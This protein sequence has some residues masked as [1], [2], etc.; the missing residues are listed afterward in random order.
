MFFSFYLN[1]SIILFSFSSCPFWQLYYLLSFFLASP[2]FSQFFLLF[3]LVVFFIYFYTSPR[4]VY[5]RT[6]LFSPPFSKRAH[7]LLED[8]EILFLI[9]APFPRED[10]NLRS[11]YATSWAPTRRYLSTTASMPNEIYLYS[12]MNRSI[13]NRCAIAWIHAGLNRV[14]L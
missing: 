8:R 1:R 9:L 13:A 3:P 6:S 14:Y 10:C 2:S 5:H 4:S 12:T 11:R 7:A